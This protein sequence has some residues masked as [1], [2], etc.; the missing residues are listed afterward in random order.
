VRWRFIQEDANARAGHEHDRSDDRSEPDRGSQ[1]DHGGDG[2]IDGLARGVT[3]GLPGR[4]DG[5]VSIRD[6][7]ALTGCF[8]GR[9][10][11]CVDGRLP[12]GVD[13][14]VSGCFADGVPGWITGRVTRW[15]AGRLAVDRDIAN[16]N[17]L[18]AKPGRLEPTAQITSRP[19][20]R[21][22]GDLCAVN[23]GRATDD[24]CVNSRHAPPM[25][26]AR[27]APA[28]LRSLVT[29]YAERIAHQLLHPEQP[30]KAAKLPTPLTQSSRSVERDGIWVGACK[31]GREQ[32]ALL[33]MACKACARIVPHAQRVWCPTYQ[34][35]KRIA[36]DH[37][38]LA[39]ANRKLSHA[40]APG[41]MRRMA[42]RR[43]RNGRKPNFC[44]SG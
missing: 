1:P 39:K 43:R 5:R 35:V 12:N 14:G 15:V 25:H 4:F 9:V 3:D 16:E 30:T 36:K 7:G 10:F 27:R 8:A 37:G 21:P 24:V 19:S 41:R 6:A 42:T 40:R 23:L 29:T 38:N 31:T 11:G 44:G 28:P 20:V 22:R 26:P 33:P 17:L 34:P 2:S 13:G 18:S 32:T